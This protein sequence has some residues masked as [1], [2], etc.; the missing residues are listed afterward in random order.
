MVVNETEL[1]MNLQETGLDGIMRSVV[2]GVVIDWAYY[3]QDFATN[4][5]QQCDPRFPALPLCVGKEAVRI[6][7]DADA[8]LRNKLLVWLEGDRSQEFSL[9]A[10]TRFATYQKHHRDYVPPR[11]VWSFQNGEF[12]FD[13]ST[14]TLNSR[15]WTE[16]L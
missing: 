16:T 7:E 10:K 3:L 11:P 6:V 14:D 9:F 5:I 4:T 15:S 12:R 2:A 8:I 1:I 13:G